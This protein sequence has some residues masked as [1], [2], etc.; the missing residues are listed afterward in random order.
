M[1]LTFLNPPETPAGVQTLKTSIYF[2]VRRRPAYA[3]SSRSPADSKWPSD[4]WLLLAS[5]YLYASRN[6]C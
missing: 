6:V 3:L 5:R 2:S 1:G 4:S